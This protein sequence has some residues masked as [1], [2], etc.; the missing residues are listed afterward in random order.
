MHVIIRATI[1]SCAFTFATAAGGVKICLKTF[2]QPVATL[3][4]CF[5]DRWK[6]TPFSEKGKLRGLN[7]YIP[8]D[9]GEYYL[10]QQIVDSGWRT[11][12]LSEAD[13]VI[14]DTFPVLSHAVGMCRGVEHDH[15][16]QEVL[17]WLKRTDTTAR[18]AFVC[19]SWTCKFAVGNDAWRV[20]QERK[21]RL[22]I[23][24]L[25]PRWIRS[26]YDVKAHGI[27]VP[28]SAHHEIRRNRYPKSVDFAFIG[29]RRD[30]H[31]FTDRV[32]R[33]LVQLKSEQDVMIKWAYPSNNRSTPLY[34]EI[35]MHAKW[36]FVPRGDT[37]S[38]RRLF[39]AMIAGCLP[40][41]ISDKIDLP[42]PDVVPY[43]EIAITVSEDEW[44]R[45]PRLT[46]RR[47]RK[48]SEKE[49]SSRQNNMDR[50]VQ[51]LDWRN[52][53][54]MLSQIVSALKNHRVMGKHSNG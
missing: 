41:I 49:I 30:R 1:L 13:V 45:D 38:S 19:T 35:M 5:Q 12:K 53:T 21:A 16:Q 34:A 7:G 18:I 42:F 44:S 28:Y 10:Y 22:L 14:L 25:Q 47:L 11:S 26:P 51:M 37:P 31:R 52:G 33:A 48:I 3:L 8:E 6:T 9:L 32:R 54:E 15:R 23:N 17:Q 50:Y 36:C 20:L 43:A 39:D 40:V 29:N 2:T 46:L 4:D 27:V 24:E